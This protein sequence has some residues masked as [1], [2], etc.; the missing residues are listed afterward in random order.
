MTA[1]QFETSREA[2]LLDFR[3]IIGEFLAGQHC[4]FAKLVVPG[5]C[6]CLPGMLY[7]WCRVYLIF[8]LRGIL[9]Y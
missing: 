9:E 2:V 3:F 5:D 6:S 7:V 1:N 8:I 4:L